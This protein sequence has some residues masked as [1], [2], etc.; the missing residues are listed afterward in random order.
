MRLPCNELP[1]HAHYSFVARNTWLIKEGDPGMLMKFYIHLTYRIAAV[2]GGFPGYTEH[3]IIKVVILCTHKTQPQWNQSHLNTG[4]Y[5]GNSCQQLPQCWKIEIK[6]NGPISRI[7]W[8][9][10][11]PRCPTWIPSTTS[12][13]IFGIPWGPTMR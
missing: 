13:F 1:A 12:Q 3:Y 5:W 10:Q 4:H 8:G 11:L 9:P 2:L 7:R 6:S